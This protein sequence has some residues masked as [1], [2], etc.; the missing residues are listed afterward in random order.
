MPLIPLR[1]LMEATI[2]YGFGQGAFNVNAVAQ[3][4]AAIEVHEMFRSP[5][6]LQGA[7]LANGF[8]G[9][10]TDFM[11]ATLEDKKIGAKNIADAVKKYGA[12]SEIP[13]VLHLDHGR[14]FDS[15]VAAISGGYTSVMI[16]GSS[17]PFDENVELTRE[18]VKYAHSRGVSVEG[19]LG[20]LAGVEDHVFSDSSTYT[21]PLKA[22]EFFRKTGVDALAI[23]YGT[24]HGASK[25][26][27]VKLRKEIAMAIRECL[28]HEGI[29]GALVSHGSSTVPKYIVDENNALGGDLTNTY[30]IAVE[31]L[32]AAISCGIN[33]INVDT[34]IR[35][36]VTRNMKEL[37]VKYPELRTSTSIGEIYELLEAK[38]SQFDPRVFLPPIMDT[39]MKGNIPDEDVAAIVNCVERGVKEVVGTLIVQF[40]SFGKAP[41]VEQV[42]LEEMIE[43]YKKN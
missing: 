28:S 5:A 7:D 10:R 19:E 21:N 16:D 40:G 34:D 31:E 12:D 27:D 1:P 37:F 41:L 32:Q 25:G 4:K 2:K 14:D 39:V 20:V 6:I 8:M 30:G 26:K 9:G 23:S 15:C 24:M 17:L 22:V 38:K 36:A 35:L 29:F 33:K 13:I 42:T 43:R 11:N 3:A 18:V